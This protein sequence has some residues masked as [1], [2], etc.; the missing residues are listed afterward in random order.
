MK[1]MVTIIRGHHRTALY[2]FRIGKA[3]PTRLV[4]AYKMQEFFEAWASDGILPSMMH[5]LDQYALFS[6]SS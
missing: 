5:A 1:L 2:L 3:I 6:R 4:L